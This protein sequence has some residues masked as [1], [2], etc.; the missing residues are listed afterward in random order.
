ML[1]NVTSD[2]IPSEFEQ[3]DPR[4]IL[5]ERVGRLIGAGV[6]AVVV[7]VLAL[8][9]YADAWLT[10]SLRHVLLAV[11]GLGVAA[12]VVAA[13]LL[14]RLVYRY[15]RYRVDAQGLEIRSGV[16]WRSVA[17]VA[18]SR[19]QHLDVT[20]G[21]L[22]RRYGL[23]RLHVHTAGTHAAT[24]ELHGVALETAAA[25]RDDLGAWGEDADGV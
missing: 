21:P 16:F 23:G 10:P 15:T 19:I 11:G 1:S 18:R 12:L 20:Q 4:V 14:P 3:L 8:V 5:Y 25:L 13:V 24:L 9:A 2:P 17:T 22:E 6:L 7:L